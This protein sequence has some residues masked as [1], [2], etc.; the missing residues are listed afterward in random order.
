MCLIGAT[1]LDE[2]Y[3]VAE[4]GDDLEGFV[5]GN[6]SDDDDISEEEEDIEEP[7]PEKKKK[8]ISKKK[9]PGFKSKLTAKLP[10][11]LGPLLSS[12]SG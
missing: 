11:V 7:Q 10:P 5:V 4:L 6:F 12:Q 8:H 3:E 2:S 9:L 1:M